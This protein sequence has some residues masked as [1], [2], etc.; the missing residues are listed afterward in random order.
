M[1]KNTLVQY[2]D[3][4]LGQTYHNWELILVDDGSYDKSY[5]ICCEYATKDERK[6]SITGRY[7]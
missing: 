6:H 2:L 5:K 7:W 1:K 3:S 4:I